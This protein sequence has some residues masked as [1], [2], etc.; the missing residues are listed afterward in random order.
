MADADADDTTAAKAADLGMILMSIARKVRSGSFRHPEIVRLSPVEAEVLHQVY[1]DPGATPGH[2]GARAGLKAPNLS[3]ALRGLERKG[4]VTRHKDA[5]DGRCVRVYATEAAKQST[6]LVRDG[7]ATVL[8]PHLNGT[9]L[10][11][12]IAYL[13]ALDERVGYDTAAD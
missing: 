7:A 3:T 13:A 5:D 8:A 12:V 10:D 9:G 1:D 11:E 2:L 6:G 4:F